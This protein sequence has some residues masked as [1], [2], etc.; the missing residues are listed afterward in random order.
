M[1]LSCAPV[2]LHPELYPENFKLIPIVCGLKL[3]NITTSP[4]LILKHTSVPVIWEV[5][6]NPYPVFLSVHLQLPNFYK[7]VPNVIEYRERHCQKLHTGSKRHR[8]S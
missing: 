3:K 6:S 1:S 5:S 7:K 2:L 8:T 4:K